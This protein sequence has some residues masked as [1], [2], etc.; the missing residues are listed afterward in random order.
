MALTQQAN[1]VV[2][3]MTGGLFAGEEDSFGSHGASILVVD[4][5]SIF[6]III[7]GL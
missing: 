5:D 4:V 1:R 2:R 6:I 3:A 7:M